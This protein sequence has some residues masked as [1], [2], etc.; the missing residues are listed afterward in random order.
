MS[1]YVLPDT[2]QDT[3]VS[4]LIIIIDYGFIVN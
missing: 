3:F 4:S 2:C 1:D